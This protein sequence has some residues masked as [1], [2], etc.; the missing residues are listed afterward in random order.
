MGWS[1]VTSDMQG[2]KML[3]TMTMDT[4]STAPI[5]TGALNLSQDHLLFKREV[6][7]FPYCLSPPLLKIFYLCFYVDI[8]IILFDLNTLSKLWS[9]AASRGD[10]NKLDGRLL[11]MHKLEII[12]LCKGV[13][14]GRILLLIIICFTQKS[15]LFLDSK[16]K[17]NMVFSIL[18]G[19]RRET[20][21]RWHRWC[22]LQISSARICGH[23]FT[24][25]NLSE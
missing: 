2:G 22:R 12:V 17:C 21:W 20:W 11:I 24:C 7:L 1:Q 9:V 25:L 3:S 23:L 6:S 13:E 19:I 4:D 15:F 18:L 16:F 10:G 8:L 5:E 14:D